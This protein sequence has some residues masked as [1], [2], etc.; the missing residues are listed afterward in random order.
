MSN[1]FLCPIVLETPYFRIFCR[2]VRKKNTFAG[3]GC[4]KQ[5]RRHLEVPGCRR[6]AAGGHQPQAGKVITGDD[7][8]NDADGDDYDDADDD[9]DEE[10]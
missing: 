2:T 9:D 5:Q 6:G 4:N 1:I 8:D 10:K 7:G 3:P